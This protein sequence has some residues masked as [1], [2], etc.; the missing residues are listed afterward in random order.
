LLKAGLGDARVG[1]VQ[2]NQG[3]LLATVERVLSGKVIGSQLEAVTG[4]AAREAVAQLFVQG[5]LFPETRRETE[6]RLK[7]RQ[8]AAVLAQREAYRH[9]GLD[10]KDEPPSLETWV[11]QRLQELGF[12]SGEDLALLSAEDLLAEDL[13][14]ELLPSLESEFPLFVDLGDCRYAVDYDLERRQVLLRIVRGRRATPPQL[15]YL[16]RFKGF[17]V[18]AEVNGSI[19][20]L[21]T[22]G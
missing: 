16:P 2:L 10:S 20:P 5:R 12:E 4:D 18:Y 6:L 22:H 8:L 21:R 17:R 7:R 9:W 13:P 11:G 15:A 14:A 1:R 19:V 3:K